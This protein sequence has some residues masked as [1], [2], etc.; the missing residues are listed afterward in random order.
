LP[1]LTIAQLYNSRCRLELFF[2]VVTENLRIKHFVRDDGERGQDAG[3][4]AICIYVLLA[5]VRNE[6]ELEVRPS[7]IL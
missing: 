2:K 5:V 1:A 7:Q 6:L 4:I 3:L